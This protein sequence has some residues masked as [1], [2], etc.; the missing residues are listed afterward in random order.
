M[1]H[2]CYKCGH[3]IE[4]GKPFCLQCGAPQI[5]VAIPE[6]PAEA[7]ADAG[8][9]SATLVHKADPGFS[10]AAISALP[11]G[12]SY[13][14]RPCALAAGVAVL[15]MFLGLNPLVA[16][17]GAGFLAVIFSPRRNVGAAIG[18]AAGARLGAL[19]G[20]LLFCMSTI[21]ETLA[22]V[23]LHKGA[24]IR[25][26][27]LDKVQQA[28]ARYPGPQVEPFMNFVKS[29]GGFVV[30]MAASLIFGL[31]A[32]AVLGGLGGAVSAAFWGRRNRK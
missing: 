4:D 3:S 31:M 29:P 11:T 5:R 19:S 22:V 20:F 13:T 9:T 15:L 18:P 25:S 28:A 30:M 10:G 14:L 1:D 26:E 2:P 17:L 7:V 8:S 12:W 23:V 24:E 6:A 32:F 21:L 27:M 16:A